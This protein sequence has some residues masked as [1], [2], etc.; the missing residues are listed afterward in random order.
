MS[1]SQRSGDCRLQSETDVSKRLRML[2]RSRWAGY[3]TRRA[4]R[5]NFGVILRPH[6]GTKSAQNQIKQWPICTLRDSLSCVVASSLGGCAMCQKAGHSPRSCRAISLRRR[7]DILPHTLHTLTALSHTYHAWL[8][9]I[10]GEAQLAAFPALPPR[11]RSG[12][13]GQPGQ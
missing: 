2:L 11:M 9:R 4:L 13:P 7:S 12:R 3:E 5:S 1:A 6:H 8:N 10:I